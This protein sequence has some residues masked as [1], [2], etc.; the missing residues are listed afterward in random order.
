MIITA[1][2]SLPT[3]L[4]D[5]CRVPSDCTGCTERGFTIQGNGSDVLI[6][7]GVLGD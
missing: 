1:N 2:Y 3:G 5:R 4:Y 7:E 6:I